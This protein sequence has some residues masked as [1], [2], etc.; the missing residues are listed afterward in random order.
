MR[1]QYSLTKVF[2]GVSMNQGRTQKLLLLMSDLP[3]PVRKNGY[4]V[5]Y[6]PIIEFLSES[7]DIHLLVISNLPTPE[8]D[9]KVMERLCSRVSVWDRKPIKVSSFRKLATFIYC[10]L[11]GTCSHSAFRYDDHQIRH[12]IKTELMNSH[13][14]VALC[15]DSRYFELVSDIANADRLVVDQIDSAYLHVLRLGTD[16]IYRW[17]EARKI[18]N[19]ER[20]TLEIADHTFYISPADLSVGSGRAKSDS[21]VS[22]I[23]NGVHIN[24][25]VDDS[26]RFGKK[27]IGYLGHMGYPP[28]IQAAE[29][30]A[31]IFREVRNDEPEAKLVIIGRDPVQSVRDL[32]KIPGVIVTGTVENIWSYLSGIDVFVFPMEIGSGQQNKILEALYS[33]KPV[34]TSSV[35]NG[36]I[37]AEA[38]KEI[39]IA[40]S[41]SEFA[42]E[43]LKLLADEKLRE[44]LGAN[45]YKFVKARYSWPAILNDIQRKLAS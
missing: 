42:E 6:Y 29:R 24:D 21:K 36:G 35:G 28:N 23:P 30:L 10:L 2:T 12:F 22:L 40:E 27:C 26:V 7:Y 33:K 8:A 32:E 44:Y 37:G 41:N 43:I 39:L 9:R 15:A 1:S 18:K 31:S 20:R 17:L 5:R 4:S 16:S 3:F 34:I 25:I 19:R 45:G 13:Y 14:D 11:P 38:G